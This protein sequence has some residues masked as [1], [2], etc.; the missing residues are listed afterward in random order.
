MYEYVEQKFMGALKV[1][2]DGRSASQ[3]EVYASYEALMNEI[4]EKYLRTL[5]GNQSNVAKTLVPKQAENSQDSYRLMCPM[6][7]T[8]TGEFFRDFYFNISGAESK[9]N[10]LP[11]TFTTDEIIFSMGEKFEVRINRYTGVAIYG[12]KERPG[13]FRGQC[14]KVEQRQ[15]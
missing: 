4:R 3:Q 14:V 8:K 2:R 1:G 7:V 9:V 5:S 12:N 11:A 13:F 15:F 10:D 6:F